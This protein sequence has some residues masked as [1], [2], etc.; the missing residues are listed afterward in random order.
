MDCPGIARTP[1]DS[2]RGAYAGLFPPSYLDHFK[3]EEQEQDWIELLTCGGDDPHAG[4][5]DPAQ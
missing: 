1:L 5:A 3:Y 4:R 2:Y